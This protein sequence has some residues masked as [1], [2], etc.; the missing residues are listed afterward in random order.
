[1]WAMRTE[2]G[3]VDH[4][5]RPHGTARSPSLK[6]HL[7]AIAISFIY[8][9]SS[10][11]AGKTLFRDRDPPDVEPPH[12]VHILKIRK[13]PIMNKA[14][15]KAKLTRSWASATG[16]VPMLVGKPA[17]LPGWSAY[18]VGDVLVLMPTLLPGAPKSIKRRYLARIVAN[19]SGTC[20]V[21]RSC[22]GDLEMSER[23]L[24]R[25]ALTHEAGCSIGDDAGMDRWLDPAAAE[26]RNAIANDPEGE[27]A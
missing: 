12:F 19:A 9:G 4:V 10:R 27:A 15:A 25:G 18:G 8:K 14:D 20:P 23:G 7:L 16:Q 6:V 17:D 24:N 22:A 3:H 2:C 26:L 1:M 21:C 13:K 5:D 11:F